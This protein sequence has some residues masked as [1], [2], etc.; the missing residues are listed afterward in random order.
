MDFKTEQA[1]VE[2]EA[3]AAQSD[4][5]DAVQSEAAAPAKL[6]VPLKTASNVEHDNA[7][8]VQP[9]IA[10]HGDPPKANFKCSMCGAPKA[11][12]ASKCANIHCTGKRMGE[13][14]CGERNVK[15]DKEEIPYAPRPGG[16]MW[17]KYGEKTPSVG[18]GQ[19][20][21]IYLK[22][23]Y[24]DCPARQTVLKYIGQLD[25]EGQHE[26][27]VDHDLQV[28]DSVCLLLFPLCRLHFPS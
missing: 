18:D 16:N 28:A 25:E 12:P 8:P 7:I 6:A 13:A 2:S 22:C 9:K 14:E 19:M 15:L 3:E 5:K 27:I 24:D 10:F 23:Q 20:R 17:R 11:A 1:T 26:L 4:Q 21:K